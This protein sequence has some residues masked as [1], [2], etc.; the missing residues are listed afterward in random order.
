MAGVD[1]GWLGGTEGDRG[2]GGTG[3]WGRLLA[4]HPLG[5]FPTRVK[6]PPPYNKNILGLY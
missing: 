6:G 4:K 1:G 5:R 3:R 2:G